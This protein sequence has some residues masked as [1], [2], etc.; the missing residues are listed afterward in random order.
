MLRRLLL[1]MT[2]LVLGCQSATEEALAEA[3]PAVVSAPSADTQTRLSTAISTLLDGTPV[4]LGPNP[5]THSSL[6]TL[7]HAPIRSI[8]G[9]A[10]GSLVL[11]KP[12]QFRLLLADSQCL[13]LRVKT[14]ERRP[15]VN[16]RCHPEPGQA[17]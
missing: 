12:E 9:P 1:L 15:I 2:G 10:T 13:L 6:L 8:E 5:F 14:G 4:R 7:E 11:G 3:V 16:L 17:P